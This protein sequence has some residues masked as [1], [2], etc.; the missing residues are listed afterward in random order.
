MENRYFVTALNRPVDCDLEQRILRGAVL[1]TTGLASDGAL[2]LP[3]GVDLE[4]YQ[5]NAVV[6]D[7]HTVN[8]GQAVD[9][10]VIGNAMA[11]AQSDLE[12]MASI[13]FPD[14]QAGRDFA[15][16]YGVN[17]KKEAF[18]RAFSVELP[19][20]DTRSISFE[21]ARK[22]S[23]QYWD[24]SLA[25]RM[26]RKVGRVILVTR[27]EIKSVAAVPVG[28]D[29]GAL[30]RAEKDGCVTA[31]RI[32]AG[33]DLDQSDRT[34]ET[35]RM[36][37]AAQGSRLQKLEE[38][39]LALRRDGTAAAARGDTAEVLARL[40]ELTQIAAARAGNCPLI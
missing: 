23:A 4:R 31:G 10:V 27:S 29:R 7:R 8:E 5:K 16:L 19:M 17:E 9:A 36:E 25:E 12:I 26:A 30:T 22:I 2:V 21:E 39:V 14:T 1:L 15:H 38:D 32:L 35:L 40:H 28:A 6:T 37:L 24:A 13:K 11:L 18:M 3:S 34:I 33:L 20:I